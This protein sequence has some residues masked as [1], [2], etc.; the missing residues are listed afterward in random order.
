M[1]PRW[2]R[3][4]DTRFEAWQH[5][6]SDE[7]SLVR[8]RGTAADRE[9]R[10]KVRLHTLGMYT[11]TDMIEYTQGRELPPEVFADPDVMEIYRIGCTA[12]LIDNDLY[13]ITKDRAATFRNLVGI[14]ARDRNLAETQI[15]QRLLEC[16]NRLIDRFT[17]VENR[18]RGDRVAL[19]IDWWLD[20]VHHLMTGLGDWHHNAPRYQTE[21]LTGEGDILHLKIVLTSPLSSND[22]PAPTEGR[23]LPRRSD[24]TCRTGRAR[25]V[26]S[27]DSKVSSIPPD[28]GW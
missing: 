28:H 16:H 10:L 8:S 2:R 13:G 5:S 26:G 12:C 20:C 3:R 25:T 19:R 27:A 15:C 18:L 23:S 9:A 7:A 17:L 21:H 4:F 22:S 24:D 14:T 6:V 1:S 11:V